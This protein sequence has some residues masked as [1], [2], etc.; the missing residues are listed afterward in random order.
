M[1]HTHPGQHAFT[2]TLLL[3]SSSASR[4][5]Y[6]DSKSLEMPAARS[7]RA[8]EQA[9]LNHTLALASALA[10]GPGLHLHLQTTA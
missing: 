10:Q 8:Y 3:A 5:V 4:R 9:A 2:A 6:M 7:A 1:P